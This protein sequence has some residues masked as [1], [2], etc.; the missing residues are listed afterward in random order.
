MQPGHLIHHEPVET[1][2]TGARAWRVRY[3]SRDIAERD[4]E[5]TGLVIAPEAA[6]TD[7]PVVTW[8]HGTTGLGDAACPSAQPD[9]AR[10]LTGYFTPQ[11]TQ[12]IDYGVPGLQ[13]MIDAGWVV[14]ATDYQGL[15]SPGVHQYM[16]SRTNARDAVFI[17]RAAR[18]LDAG[19]GVRLAAIGWSQGGGAAAALC[20]LD[21]ADF[22]DLDLVGSVLYSPG[23]ASVA[24]AMPSGESAALSDPSV[25]P[26]AHLV[27]MIAG[28][29]AATDG[30]DLGDLLTPLGVEH[31]ETAWNHQ[32]VHH[33]DDTIKRLFHLRGAII[34]ADPQNFD[35]WK[36]A[37]V[38][39][40]AGRTAPLCP[41]LMCV[42][43]FNGGAVVPVAWQ[44]AYAQ[45]V[46]GL[47]ASIERLEFPHDDH[48]SLPGAAAPQAQAWL[49]TRLHS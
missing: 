38:A 39:S 40:S 41:I 48:F 46:A 45:I 11:S 36:Q 26:S 49:A 17:A 22:G 43:G 28:V 29:A 8:C 7:R 6:G 15:G 37:I 16:A 9:P 25:A 20:E 32:P 34:R 10:E 13:A 27:M 4:Q 3:L 2:I 24:L 18:H 31:I 1:S 33:L 23:V 12:Q 30:L 35:A 21:V 19:A 14:C 44:D 47:G 42:D 5:T